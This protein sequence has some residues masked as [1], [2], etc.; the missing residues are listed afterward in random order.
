MEGSGAN[1]GLLPLP[2]LISANFMEDLANVELQNTWYPSVFDLVHGSYVLFLS[3][4]T[5]VKETCCIKI[6]YH[7]VD[8]SQPSWVLLITQ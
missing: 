2:H 3:L 6:I 1:T 7:C 5:A 8:K 4:R